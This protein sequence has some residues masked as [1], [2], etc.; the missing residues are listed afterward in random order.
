MR[1]EPRAPTASKC[2]AALLALLL[3]LASCSHPLLLKKYSPTNPPVAGLKG[4]SIFVAPFTFEGRHEWSGTEPL[5]DPPRFTPVSPTDAQM[6]QWEEERRKLG[7]GKSVAEQFKVGHKRNGFGMPIAE[8]FSVS[9]P[10]QWLTEATRLE[11]TTQGAIAAPSAEAADVV[12][13]GV[14]RHLFLD[15][16]M[17]TWVHLV[18][19]VTTTPR[20]QA[21]NQVRLH[22]TD[23]RL[24]WSGNDAESYEI[25]STTEQKLQ[26]Y[27]LDEIARAAARVDQAPAAPF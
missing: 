4:R 7:E 20:G 13:H 15:L 17:T 3:A 22:I 16:Y 1:A 18:V 8:V 12:V 5:A 23:S 24:A 21:P 27:L 10:G 14:V 19:D 11:L 9:S 26:R 6:D 2:A 25:F